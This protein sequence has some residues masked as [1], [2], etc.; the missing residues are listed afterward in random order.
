[1]TG[2]KTIEQAEQ[3]TEVPFSLL[4]ATYAVAD[5]RTP[6]FARTDYQFCTV[7]YVVKGAGE[8]KINGKTF[9]PEQDSIYFLTKGSNHS[10]SPNREDP[11][12]KYFFVVDGSLMESLLKIYR[13]DEI[14]Y[15]PD[16][17]A[18]KHYFEEMMNL[19]PSSSTVNQQ[20]A[21]LFHRFVSDL[22]DAVYG[23]P[24]TL[25]AEVEK[26]KTEL[27]SSL[28]R[29]FNLEDYSREHSYSDA[30]LIR[31]FKQSFGVT[32]YDYLMQ[33]KVEFAKRLLLYS[34]FSIKEIAAHLCFSDQYYFS[35]YFKMKTGV[36]PKNYKSANSRLAEP[37]DRKKGT[38]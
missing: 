26:L 5:S 33:Q 19:I 9:Y 29:S 22:A 34:S 12:R 27:D 32:P 30:H 1:M 13:L 8:L 16:C 10:Y 35:N 11:W 21:L 31:V 2:R 15:V 4:A 25:P 18:F 7:E 24:S 3:G 38:L 23:V 36:S 28:T 6:V 14:Y 20:S 37:S 17:A